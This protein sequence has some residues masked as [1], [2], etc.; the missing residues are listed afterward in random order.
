[1]VV[2]S[3]W[4]LMSDVIPNDHCRQVQSTYYVRKLAVLQRPSRVADLGCGVGRSEAIFR[5]LVPSVQWIGV[6]I[7]ESP[8]VLQ[9]TTRA[10]ALV[11]YD[12]VNLPFRSESFPLIYSHQVFEHVRFPE[13]LIAEIG[14]VLINGGH[15]IGSTSQLE[16]YHS[17]SLWN[18]TVYGFRR[19]VEDAGLTMV[20][21]R[22]GIDGPTLI[23]RQYE[24]RP[25]ELN[26]YFQAESPLNSEIDSWGKQTRRE[27]A[28]INSRKLQFC[29][30]FVFHVRKGMD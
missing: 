10:A 23:R 30:Q 24:G 21:V 26:Q 22:P 16:P 17:F 2:S 8:E 19:L 12:G 15:F 28:L 1:V 3:F 13:A 4:D 25:P 7:P 14:R 20:E 27:P 6:D 18:Y 11:T 29:G 9:R 5:G